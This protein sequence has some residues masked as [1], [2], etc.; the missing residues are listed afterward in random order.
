MNCFVRQI[1]PHPYPLP[2]KDGERGSPTSKPP[3]PRGEGKGEGRGTIA[4][5]LA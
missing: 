3:S 2:V 5:V 1:A 4:E